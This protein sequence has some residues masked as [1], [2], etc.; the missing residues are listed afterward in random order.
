M[1][2][3]STVSLMRNVILSADDSY[4]N[5]MRMQGYRSFCVSNSWKPIYVKCCH[6]KSTPNGLSRNKCH[7][8]GNRTIIACLV[9]HNKCIILCGEMVPI[10][11]IGSSCLDCDKSS[12]TPTQREQRW[13]LLQLESRPGQVINSD[14]LFWRIQANFLSPGNSDG[15]RLPIGWHL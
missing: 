7:R 4:I 3:R 9:P 2:L 12:T 11:S 15:L 6:L 8:P 13:P 10:T 14:T 1:W 5:M